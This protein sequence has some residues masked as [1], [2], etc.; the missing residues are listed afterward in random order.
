MGFFRAFVYMFLLSLE[1]LAYDLLQLILLPISAIY[2]PLVRAVNGYCVSVIVE[3]FVYLLEHI[4]RPQV[5]ITGD[6]LVRNQS[7]LVIANHQSYTDSLIISG[8]ALRY[9]MLSHIKFFAKDSLKWIPI[10]GWG[11]WL[12]GNILV[13]RNWHDDEKKITEMFD[14]WKRSRH[15]IW[16]VSY[17]EGSRRTPE[18]VKSSQTFARER[19]LPLLTRVLTPRT[20]GF[21][22]TVHSL[23]NTHIRY[24]YDLTIRYDPS[25]PTIYDVFAHKLKEMK[26]IIHIKR[27]DISELPTDTYELTRWLYERFQEKDKLLEKMQHGDIPSPNTMTPPLQF[28]VTRI[29]LTAFFVVADRKSVV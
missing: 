12:M 8:I 13:K 3:G 9:G 4:D 5:I 23:R 24:V 20:K 28:H 16:L 11:I 19:Q 29:Y 18:K 15:P 17:P 27:Y 10:L 21:V 6:P 25:V 14:E 1:L 22:A 2:P 26:L 7:A